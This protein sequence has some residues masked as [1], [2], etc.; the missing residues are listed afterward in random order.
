MVEKATPCRRRGRPCPGDP[1]KTI[2]GTRFFIEKELADIQRRVDEV[3]DSKQQLG[4]LD[5]VG[6]E[7]R[8]RCNK[9]VLA[10]CRLRLR[11]IEAVKKA[12]GVE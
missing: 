11:R 6:R 8:L 2:E 4:G 12:R 1:T 10:N 9:L 7:H 3:L 5:Q